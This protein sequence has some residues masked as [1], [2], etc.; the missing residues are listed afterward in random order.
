MVWAIVRRYVQR[1]YRIRIKSKPEHALGSS[2]PCCIGVTG[3]GAEA[4]RI[5]WKAP[6]TTRSGRSSAT[7]SPPLFDGMSHTQRWHQ[8]WWMAHVFSFVVFLVILPVTMLRHMFTSPL[9]MYL[10]TRTAPRA[11]CADAEP[12]GDR[13]RELRRLHRRG[14]HL[15]A[16]ARHRRLHHVRPLHQRVPGSRHRQ[17]AR[18]P[19]DRAQDRRGHGR[20]G[21]PVGVARRSAPTAEITISDPT[22]CSSGSPPKRS[23]P[24]PPA[25][26]ATR[27]ARST[28]RSSTRSSTCAATCRS[29]S[30]TSPPSSA[31]PTAAW[32]TPATRGA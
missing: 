7:R 3:F 32:R 10:R 18:P 16:A 29:W 1:P 14:L 27:S 28:S 22:R 23:G 21:H 4:F 9:N 26:P 25:R 24:A 6:P 5:A 13:A 11:P 12:H 30:R 19:R 2:A 15:E 20:L 31:T 8:I 17:A